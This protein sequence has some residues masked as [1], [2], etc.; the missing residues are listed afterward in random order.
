MKS[1]L[2]K[3]TAKE[4][5]TIT[6]KTMQSRNVPLVV[7]NLAQICLDKKLSAKVEVLSSAQGVPTERVV[8]QLLK[9]NVD[10]LWKKYR[11]AV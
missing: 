11:R 1:K 2:E 5:E 8:N 3:L 7:S 4:I 10:R 9:E 6:R